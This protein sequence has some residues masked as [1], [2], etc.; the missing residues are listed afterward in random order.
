MRRRHRHH[1]PTAGHKFSI[2][3]QE[4]GRLVSVAICD[5]RVSRF[6]ADGYT[7]EV[8]RLCTDGARNTSWI[9]NLKENGA[10]I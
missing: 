8:N 4:D 10:Q 7:L 6:L 5:R 3:I 1:K 9:K 2:G